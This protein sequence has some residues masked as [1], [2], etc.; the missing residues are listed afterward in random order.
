MTEV[1]TPVRLIQATAL[2]EGI[3]GEMPCLH[4]TKY[5]LGLQVTDKK[6][7]SYC[8]FWFR[9]IRYEIH[10][11]DTIRSFYLYV[12]FRMASFRDQLKLKPQLH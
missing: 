9:P 8:V 10:S 5:H 1:S 4:P 3:Q 2:T 6:I 7:Q 12:C 11:L